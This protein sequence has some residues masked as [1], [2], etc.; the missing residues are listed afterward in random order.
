MISCLS[1]AFDVSAS[2][3][4]SFSIPPSVDVSLGQFWKVRIKLL[5]AGMDPVLLL[6]HLDLEEVNSEKSN[7]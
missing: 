5:S 4:T 6:E 1:E 3:V 7:L 2:L